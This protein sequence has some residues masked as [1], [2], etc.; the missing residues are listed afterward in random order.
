MYVVSK[1]INIIPQ[2]TKLVSASQA[3]WDQRFLFF[4]V[5]Y[6]TTCCIIKCGSVFG[7]CAWRLVLQLWWGHEPHSSQ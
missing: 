1:V 4:S 6:E 2:M 3:S 7:A 5:Y